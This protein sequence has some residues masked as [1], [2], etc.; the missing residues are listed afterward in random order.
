[1]A[2]MPRLLCYGVGGGGG[3]G[4]AGVQRTLQDTCHP[5][6]RHLVYRG[7]VPGSSR[8]RCLHPEPDE[9]H[10]T[11]SVQIFRRDPTVMPVQPGGQKRHSFRRGSDTQ[12]KILENGTSFPRGERITG[13]DLRPPRALRQDLRRYRV[14]RQRAVQQSQDHPSSAPLSWSMSS[15]SRSVVAAKVRISS[16]KNISRYTPGAHRNSGK[17]VHESKGTGKNS[18]FVEKPAQ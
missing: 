8:V 12:I 11:A 15:A 14:C 7:G 13:D 9:N 17:R 4:G 5:C 2:A 16:S 3:G 6:V 10:A 1:M 18:K